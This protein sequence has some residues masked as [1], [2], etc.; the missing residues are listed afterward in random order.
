MLEGRT[1][2]AADVYAFGVTL[3]ELYTSARA[4]DGVPRALLG[5][6]IAREGLRPRFPEGAPAAYRALAERC[7]HPLWELRP[8]FADA[9]A[10]LLAMR[11]ADAR[12][13]PPVHIALRPAR[14]G[15]SSAATGAAAAAASLAGATSGAGNGGGGGVSGTLPGGTPP[16]GSAQPLGS[17][18]DAMPGAA[19]GAMA[20]GGGLLVIGGGAPAGAA[21]SS[22]SV[23]LDASLDGSSAD[24]GPPEW[25]RGASG[26]SALAPMV[27]RARS[28]APGGLLPMPQIAEASEAEGRAAAGAATDSADGT[29]ST[30]AGTDGCGGGG[31]GGGGAAAAA[32]VSGGGGGGDAAARRQGGAW[33]NR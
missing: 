30:A 9:L 29:V 4:F 19:G 24:D 16:L 11:A 14:R 18:G 28:G 13:T 1:S 26:V 17:A 12:P 20:A 22:A 5:H 8:T 15:G 23:Y 27:A 31:G 2:K 32:A 6:Q 3:W 7:W 10:E 33:L 25:A 21:A